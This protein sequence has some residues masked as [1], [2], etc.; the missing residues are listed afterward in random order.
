[1]LASRPPNDLT[2][3]TTTRA[4]TQH[5][6]NL[7]Y[8][9][10]RVAILDWGLVTDIPPD[11]SLNLLSYVTHLSIEDW[12]GVARD[13]VSLGFVKEGAQDPVEAGI[14][15]P[16]GAVL[17]QLSQG[18]GAKGV[19]VAAVTAEL[20]DLTTRYPNLQIPSYFALIL[21]AFSTIEGVLL[22]C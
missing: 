17:R 21:R 3:P 11:I 14:A 9:D 1:V 19:D 6:G 15:K 10:G 16:L 7:L 12:E 18:G 8:A 20:E 4:R 2:T 22:L 5:P 13:L